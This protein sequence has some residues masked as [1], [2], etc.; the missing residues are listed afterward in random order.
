MQWL[1]RSSAIII[2]YTN[3]IFLDFATK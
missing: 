1:L 2:Y 3:Y